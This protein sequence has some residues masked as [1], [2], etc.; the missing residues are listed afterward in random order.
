MFLLHGVS[1]D[2]DKM[3]LGSLVYLIFQKKQLRLQPPR[4]TVTVK[5]SFSNLTLPFVLVS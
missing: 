4:Q 2:G 3:L 1:L 5:N